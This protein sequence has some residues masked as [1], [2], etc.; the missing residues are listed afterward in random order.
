MYFRAAPAAGGLDWI[1]R[2]LLHGILLW[3]RFSSASDRAVT[4]LIAFFRAFL[5]AVSQAIGTA[6]IK[7]ALDLLPTT[8]STIRQLLGLTDCNFR[9]YAVCEKCHCIYPLNEDG[10][11]NV[12]R[13]NYIKWPQH[14]MHSKR[15]RC[16]K[17]LLDGHDKPLRVYVTYS[18]QEYIS[19]FTKDPKFILQCNS[20]KTRR[21]APGLYQDVYDG[22]LWKEQT[23]YLTASPT[24]LLGMLNV[25][26]FQ[27]YKH[28]QYSA[29]AIYMVILNLP[30]AIRFTESNLMLLGVIPGPTEPP[31]NM[32]SY[33][34]PIVSEL[35]RFEEGV[36]VRDGTKYGNIYRFRLLGLCSDLPATRKIGG[37][38][39]F[40]A[41][42]GMFL[43]YFLAIVTATTAA[44]QHVTACN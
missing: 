22:N 3:Q 42:L 34:E 36:F 43:V 31:L 7:D 37:F 41:A 44:G 15:K 28:S 24:N 26:W 4:S 12:K 33:L 2:T 16:G 35:K 23:D 20:W 14:T 17:L 13:C 25:D 11:P 1:G 32:N 38:L 21:D 27:P 30:R 19:R 8:L 5:L 18:I 40:S 29:G 10:Q 9:S 6:A 39:S